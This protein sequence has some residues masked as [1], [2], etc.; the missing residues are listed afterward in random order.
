MGKDANLC[1][2]VWFHRCLL[3]LRWML[4]KANSCEDELALERLM[5]LR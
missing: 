3:R 4:I 1:L 2:H 5:P